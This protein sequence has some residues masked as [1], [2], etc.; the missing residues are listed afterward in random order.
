MQPCP[1]KARLMCTSGPQ[2][3]SK[4]AEGSLSKIEYA[5]W[6]INVQQG[7]KPP[8]SKAPQRGK[9]ALFGGFTAILV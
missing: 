5:K 6:V 4:Y 9:H 7:E 1:I 2:L 8:Q 3:L